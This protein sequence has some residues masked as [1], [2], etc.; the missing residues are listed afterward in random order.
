M[1]S[2]AGPTV[3]SDEMEDLVKKFTELKARREKLR[4]ELNRVSG[5]GSLPPDLQK[6]REVISS[7]KTYLESL[8]QTQSNRLGS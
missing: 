2:K 7:K 5:D 8:L 4:E 6:A 3:T 1:Q